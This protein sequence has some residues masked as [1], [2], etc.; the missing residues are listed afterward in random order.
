M[1]LRRTGHFYRPGNRARSLPDGQIRTA[2]QKQG[3][4]ECMVSIGK[5]DALGSP[6]GDRQGLAQEG[7]KLPVAVIRARVSRM[8]CA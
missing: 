8:S 5:L 7:G 1:I 6:V 4:V 3:K 2:D